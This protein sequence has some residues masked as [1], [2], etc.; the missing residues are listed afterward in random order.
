MRAAIKMKWNSVI[1]SISSAGRTRNG[2]S[3]VFSWVLACFSVGAAAADIESLTQALPL[4]QAYT[5]GADG[6]ALDYIR[7]AVVQA[8]TDDGAR[9]ALADTLASLLSDSASTDEFK[10]FVCRQLYLI[11]GEGQIDELLPL[12]LNPDLAHMA[13]YALEVMPSSKVD[14]LLWSAIPSVDGTVAAGLVSSLAARGGVGAPAH[15]SQLLL[16]D[17][18]VVVR[19]AIIGLGRLGGPSVELALRHAHATLPESLH[20][21][22]LASLL[23]CA[24][25]YGESGNRSEA[26]RL[27]KELMAPELP[28]VTRIGAFHGLVAV[29]G[30]LAVPVVLER[31]VSGEAAWIAAALSCV[32]TAG[33]S[34]ATEY[35]SA[36]LA[37]LNDEMKVVLI[38]ALADRADPVA[39]G[40]VIEAFESLVGPVQLAALHALGTLGNETHVPLLV[41]V[42]MG[43]DE[44][45]AQV[46]G[47]SLRNMADLGV[48]AALL[49]LLDGS[50]PATQ[51]A[52]MDILAARRVRAAVPQ[53]LQTAGEESGE[54]REGAF[55]AIGQLA[56]MEELPAVFERYL[57]MDSEDSR[58]MAS[59]AL[60]AIG[61]RALPGEA[62]SAMFTEMYGVAPSSITR[63]ALLAVYRELGDDSF[64]PLVTEALNSSDSLEHQ[65]GFDALVGWPT[66]TPRDAVLALAGETDVEAKR[67]AALEGY[68]RMLRL[69]GKPSV[70][71]SLAGLQDVLKLSKDAELVRHV[72][73]VLSELEGPTALSL[74]ESF[75]GREE[76]HE[77]AARAAEKIRSHFY[78]ATASVHGEQAAHMIDG[79]INTK[80]DGGESQVAGQWIALDMSLP[81]RIKGIELDNSRDVTRFPKAYEVYVF[82]RGAPPGEPVA[83]GVGVEGKTRISFSPVTGQVIRVVQTGSTSEPGWSVQEFRVIPD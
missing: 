38:D 18:D 4:A 27:Y 2:W 51:V 34:V 76:V 43:D 53:L 60:V 82:D 26:T 39:I 20:T 54:V 59:R 79:E 21:E 12:L 25:H 67:I 40:G 56:V 29:Q 48:N 6:A 33:T 13:R 81:A 44:E 30:D 41:D 42:L 52:L 7:E 55:K 71:A 22:I 78:T 73:S 69:P 61:R 83:K 45:R 65:F 11:G 23:A 5:Y 66:A 31:L 58:K 72:L 37:Q 28:E 64:L 63:G 15:L 47:E 32:R 77:A 50:G 10:A 14:E 36:A 3:L 57:L 46:A 16:H 19:A 68:I 49:Q 8:Q 17:N 24:D 9:T 74:A 70:D 75:L 35:F 62:R 80:W 1:M